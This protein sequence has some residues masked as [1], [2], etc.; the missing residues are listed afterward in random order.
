MTQLKNFEI[1]DP[2]SMVCKLKWSIYG[3][4]QASRLCN[5]KN[6]T[7][8]SYDFESNVVEN[9]IYHKHCRSNF[10]FPM[11]YVEDILLTS[12]DIG[13][14]HKTK[15]F[16]TNHFKMKYL[17]DAFFVLGIKIHRDHS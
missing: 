15:R 2:K 7:I 17:G 11:L 3:I 13:L 6:Q 8:V 5:H 1:G 10:L 4:K 9:C 12:N 14:L 16:L